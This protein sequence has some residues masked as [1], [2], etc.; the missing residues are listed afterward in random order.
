MTEQEIIEGNKLIAEFFGA[1]RSASSNYSHVNIFY[2]DY[3]N[4]TRVG[5]LSLSYRQLWD[6]LMPVVEKI[7]TIHDDHHGYFGVHIHANCCDIQG[8]NLH[9]AINDLDGYGSV[10]MSDPTAVF[11]TKIESTWY[12]C[13]QFIKWYN[14]KP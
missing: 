11:P 1:K 3:P 6:W 13:V 12:A 14:S 7:E 9:L 4:G 10:Y 5:E 2:Y 8:T